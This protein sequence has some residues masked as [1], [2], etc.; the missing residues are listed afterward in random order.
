[1]MSVSA[2]TRCRTTINFRRVSV[3]VAMS[4]T[5]LELYTD[6]EEVSDY[7][8]G[9][10]IKGRKRRTAKKATKDVGKEEEQGSR[11]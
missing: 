9:L 10:S 7:G 11:E 2:K 5:S 3:C 1:M 4:P 6:G 8:S